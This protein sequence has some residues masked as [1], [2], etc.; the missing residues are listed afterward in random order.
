[1]DFKSF[2]DSFP[3]LM[4]YFAPGVVF[5]RTFEFLTRATERSEEY[6]FEKTLVYSTVIGCIVAIPIHLVNLINTLPPIIQLAIAFFLAFTLALL[7]AKVSQQEWCKKIFKKTTQRTNNDSIWLNIFPPTKGAAVKVEGQYHGSDVQITGIVKFF[8]V[9]KNE[10]CIIVL[11]N[12]SIKGDG[13]SISGAA[14][15]TYVF[16]TRDIRYIEVSEGE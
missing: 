10:D 16:S 9:Q 13:I 8:E 12:Y 1:M 6:P 14:S 5:L 2:F 15:Q 4:M 7:L 3:I 11:S